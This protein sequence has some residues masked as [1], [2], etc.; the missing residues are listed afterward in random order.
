MYVKTLP[1][2]F[3]GHGMA[4]LM[5]GGPFLVGGPSCKYDSVTHVPGKAFCT[6]H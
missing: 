2:C 6:L 4:F 5:G 1:F 3:L